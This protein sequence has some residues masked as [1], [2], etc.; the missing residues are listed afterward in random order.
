[1]EEFDRW[2]VVVVVV[3]CLKWYDW[4]YGGDGIELDGSV[5]G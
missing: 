5:C 2:H 4:N 3:V 1:M